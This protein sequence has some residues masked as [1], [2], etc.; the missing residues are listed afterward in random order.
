[1]NEFVILLVVYAVIGT[2]ISILVMRA[3]QSQ[4][5]YFIG[6][7]A[8]GWVVSAMTYAATTYSAFMMVGLVGLSY[9]TGV[10]ALIFEMAYLVATLILLSV[11]GGRIW[12]MGRDRGYVSPMEMFSDRYGPL[13]GSLGAVVAFVALIPYTS[14][15]V[16]GLALIF[17]TYE[18]SF[19]TGII[20]AAVII[21]I[22]ALLGGLR[23]VAITDA[24]QG[25]FMIALAVIAVIWCGRRFGGVE[26]STFPNQVW[27]PVFFINLTLPWCFFAL[28]NPQ[29]V[30]RLFILK[31]K[32][33]LRKMLLL[34]GVFGALYTLIVTFIGFSAKFGTLAGAFPQVTDRD[35]TIVNVL[36]QMGRWLALPL[37]LTIVFASVTTANSII[38]SLSSMLTR[39]LL[40]QKRSVWS[41]RLFI[42]VLTVLVVL[43]SL[44]RPNYL[45]ELS[46][47]SS[48]ILMVFLP[49]FLGLFHLKIGGRMAGA[50][51]LIGGGALAVLFGVLGLRLSSVWTILAVFGM[52]FLGAALD[53]ALK[54]GKSR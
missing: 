33:D 23:G 34:F 51:T 45:V 16:I 49:L 2:V 14:V 46:V 50:L 22:W 40:R 53:G 52:F 43:F 47:S 28:T 26:L 9:A 19:T 44:T 41:G 29:V 27:T 15:Q 11:Y 42:V 5:D 6:N 7:G 31:R 8:I 37:A 12:Q 35:T 21:C 30:Q 13:T 48:R 36:A 10:G 32:K 39:D 3:R 38:L 54:F 20:V 25:A 17:Q 24:L 4:A 18:I 1:M